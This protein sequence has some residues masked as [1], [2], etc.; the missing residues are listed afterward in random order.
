MKN[1]SYL[2]T[3]V[4]NTPLMISQDK[5]EIILSVLGPRMNLDITPYSAVD[6]SVPKRYRPEDA[7]ADGIGIVPIYGT[8]VHRILGVDATSEL[9]SYTQINSWF[10]EALRDP[11]IKS[12]LLDIDSPGGE[13]SGL[14]G[15]VD[16]IY[17]ARSI[18]PIYAMINESAYSAAYALASA[19][20]AVFIP[21]TGGT[22]SIGVIIV[23][24]DQSKFDEK[25]GAKYNIIYAGD[26]KKDFTSHEPLSKNVLAIGQG[27]V[28]DLRTIFV[29][30]VAKNRRISAQVVRDTE[31]AIYQGQSAVD[32][33]LV[34]DVMS[35]SQLIENI[36]K[37]NQKG[38]KSM[39]WF[40]RK[41]AV[42]DQVRAAQATQVNAQTEEDLTPEQVYAQGYKEGLEAGKAE[43]AAIAKAELQ[44]AIQASTQTGIQQGVEQER[45]R[46]VQ[47]SEQVAAIAH[48]VPVAAASTLLNSVVKSGATP[49]M[50]GQQIIGILAGQQQNTLV[51]STVNA[52][53]TGEVNQLLVDARRRAQAAQKG[54]AN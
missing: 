42:A 18:K 43:G 54:A 35:Y 6:V 26:R 32:I 47:V 37:S 30:S 24:L 45:A 16:T 25:I 34:D 3:R 15:L 1:L 7:S 39:S 50:A 19:A 31:A 49:E 23:H 4:F 17:Q 27:I 53:S 11:L 33:G 9:V 44:T 20:E 29:D 40:D 22:G 12:I 28:N 2:A 41:K 21:P 46:C 48:L 8:L 51:V 13:I 38:G 36:T 5:A 14:F 10:T 52:T